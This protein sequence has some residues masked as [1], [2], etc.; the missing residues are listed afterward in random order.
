ML[1]YFWKTRI[2]AIGLLA[3]SHGAVSAEINDNRDKLDDDPTKVQ[4]K[5]SEFGVQIM[6]P[7]FISQPEQP[8]L[9]TKSNWFT[10]PANQDESGRSR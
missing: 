3:L 8:V 9:V 2:Q 4:T 5:F 10:P 6:S 1:R 7:N